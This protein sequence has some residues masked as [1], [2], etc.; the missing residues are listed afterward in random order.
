MP[1]QTTYVYIS[2]CSAITPHFALGRLVYLQIAKR[3]I[4][5]RLQTYISGTPFVMC[6]RWNGWRSRLMYGA[7]GGKRTTAP[8]AADLRYN[9]RE[10]GAPRTANGQN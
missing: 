2:F 9:R 4:C 6:S 3:T 5:Q 10:I 8:H 1:A 7:C